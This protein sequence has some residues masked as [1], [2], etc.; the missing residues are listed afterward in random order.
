MAQN[1]R[2]RK[3]LVMLV[4]VVVVPVTGLSAYTIYSNLQQ[5]LEDANQL[6]MALA[7][8]TAVNT[9]RYIDSRKN[10]LARIAERPQ[11]QRMEPQNCDPILEDFHVLEAGFNNV[12]V[13]DKEGLVVC[14]AVAVSR[15][16]SY[17]DSDNYQRVKRNDAFVVG[18][19]SFGK[20]SQ[21]WI[22]PLAYPIHDTQGRFNGLLGAAI[23]LIAYSPMHGFDALPEGTHAELVTS[24][25]TIIAHSHKAQELVGKQI[26]RQ[27]LRKL[28][29]Q[30]ASDSS[31]LPRWEG[32]EMI[33]GSHAVPASDWYA[34]ISIPTASILA[35]AFNTA[36]YHLGLL[37]VILFVAAG[38]A[39]VIASRIEK[40]IRSIAATANAVAGGQ[41]Q[42]R[43]TTTGPDEIAVVASE[44]NQMLDQRERAE[45]LLREQ[46]EHMRLAMDAANQASWEWHIKQDRMTC[47]DNM[48]SLLGLES[49]A[50]YRNYQDFINFIH[51]EDRARVHHAVKE[52]RNNGS[53]YAC[54]YRVIWSDGSVHW[55]A[56]RGQL[57]KDDNGQP[58]RML[59][60]CMDITERMQSDQQMR[61]LASHDS[62]TELVNRREFENRLQILLMSAHRQ[63]CEH[64]VLYMD[65]DQFKVVNDTCGHIAGDELLRQ[66]AS[67]LNKRIRESD[68]LARLGG[69]E[70]V[71]LLENCS[72]ENACQ[73]AEELRQTVLD[74]NFV[75]QQH[76]FKLG[77]SIGL[78][79]ITDDRLS[80]EQILSAA[81]AACFIAKDLGRNRVHI[82][83]A[84]DTALARHHGQMQWVT[85]IHR[86]FTES[87]LRLYCQA[88]APLR[89]AAREHCEVLVRMID[90]DGTLIPPMAFIPAAERYSLMPQIDRWVINSTFAALQEQSG[91]QPFDCICNINLSATSL[92]DADFLEFIRE[93][94]S[95]YQI[96]P[97]SICFEITETAAIAN[98]PQA[99]HFIDSLKALGCLIALDDFGSGMSSFTYLKNFSVDYLKIDGSFVLDIADDVIDRAMV[100]AIN[101]IGHVMNIE[102]IAECVENE[103]ILAQLRE[104]D[105]DY[106]QGFAIARPVP[107]RDFI[108]NAVIGNS[109]SIERASVSQTAE[110]FSS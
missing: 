2:I 44:F 25:G 50:L 29:G 91:T 97:D 109:G 16:I 99:M 81:D 55:L 101:R 86:A 8:I 95:L 11:V 43:L 30:P 39:Y 78:V 92:N 18:N 74:F 49:G 13:L 58:E 102:T 3:Y 68:T 24:N 42:S 21:K 14:S 79:P 54:E 103:A 72:Q 65:L 31:R 35:Q 20:I 28:I 23:D 7:E 60:I 47:S 94:F 41:L 10:I 80:L 45:Q 59:G 19:P 52:T 46:A 40:P 56:A 76:G 5:H 105:V 22:L 26:E 93:Q 96:E 9:G 1:W 108:Y 27:E 84:D 64:A 87:R 38:M 37:L 53:A 66:L 34:I 98:L 48:W 83:A 73:L 110:G 12:V 100:E 88:I 75:W 89:T 67:L 107:F 6:A 63:S 51:A 70:F 36:I 57:L 106:V 90:D 17:A 85:R 62:L 77:I 71:V 32:R 4:L 61:Y 69:D 82:H 104:I 33:V 15:N